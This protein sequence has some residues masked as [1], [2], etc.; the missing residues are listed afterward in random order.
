MTDAAQ[1]S[2][3]S[4]A[5]STATAGQAGAA[6]A[7]NAGASQAAAQTGAA[8]TGGNG[9]GAAA[10]FAGL[11]PEPATAQLLETKGFKNINEFSKAYHDLEK[12]VGAKGVPLPGEK[13]TDEDWGKFHAQIPGYP[14][15]AEEYKVPLPSAD[16]KP[17]EA[18]AGYHKAITAAAH[19]AGLTQRQLD[20]IGGAHNEAMASV[21]KSMKDAA[22]AEIATGEAAIEALKQE[23]GAKANANLALAQRTA[24]SLLPKDSPL[25]DQLDKLMGAA[26][27]VDF[28]YRVG[29]QF[30]ESGGVL[31]AAGG[32]GAAMTPEQAMAE[33]D[34]YNQEI[35]ADA[36]HAYKDPNNPGYA[37]AQ[38]KM[39]RFHKI[40]YPGVIG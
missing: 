24:Q 36:K 9:N 4:A 34:K 22:A 1:N 13:A 31:K 10:W 19:K 26:P 6:A 27:F 38:E 7:G 3:T 17:S 32:N 12:V 14:K 2:G 35:L 25:Y 28:M 20:I 23:W 39:M 33:I 11:G 29:T 15:S 21:G 16:Y 8:A 40:A 18:E 30:S 5:A 37:Q